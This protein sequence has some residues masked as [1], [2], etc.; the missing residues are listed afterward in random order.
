LKPSRNSSSAFLAMSKP[1]GSASSS[2]RT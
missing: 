1:C 2:N